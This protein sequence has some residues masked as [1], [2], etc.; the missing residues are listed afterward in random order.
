MASRVRDFASCINSRS[1]F[2]DQPVSL[3]GILAFCPTCLQP[4]TCWPI[5]EFQSSYPYAKPSNLTK[6]VVTV[7]P[8]WQFTS[9]R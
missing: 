1:V 2:I 7:L 9:G 8:G 3:R 5:G 6:S 4:Q